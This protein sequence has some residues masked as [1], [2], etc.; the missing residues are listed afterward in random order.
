MRTL[1]LNCTWLHSAR[2]KRINR[3]FRCIVI[4]LADG[5]MAS[6]ILQLYASMLTN[7]RISKILI[8]SL[9]LKKQKNV[10]WNIPTTGWCSTSELIAVSYILVL[11]HVIFL[12]VVGNA[13]YLYHLHA[14]AIASVVFHFNQKSTSSHHLKI[15][16]RL[17][18]RSMR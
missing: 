15:D 3:H 4:P 11:R 9:L 5:S 13:R 17:F 10:W 2:I 18:R 7:A 14:T 8:V 12:W 6:F 16:W 1:R